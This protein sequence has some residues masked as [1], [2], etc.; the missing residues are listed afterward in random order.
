MMLQLSLQILF[1]PEWNFVLFF[2]N[3]EH[4][5]KI[6]CFMCLQLPFML[7]IGVTSLK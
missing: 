5:F 6:Q 1:N 7:S 2:S 4:A 3:N